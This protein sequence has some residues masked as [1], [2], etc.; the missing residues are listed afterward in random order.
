MVPSAAVKKK[1]S[2]QQPPVPSMRTVVRILTRG[3]G[4]MLP[5]RADRQPSTNRHGSGC[6][7]RVPES[8]SGGGDTSR[9][10]SRCVPEASCPASR[11]QRSPRSLSRMLVISARRGS[12][13]WSR[14]ASR[15]QASGLRPQASSGCSDC[16]ACVS[17]L[18]SKRHMLCRY[19]RQF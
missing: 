14:P 2:G 9:A 19:R 10:M 6:E 16:A 15:P 1:A 7:V 11:R 13:A 12:C 17:S 4:E 5:F 8:I 18:L 3:G